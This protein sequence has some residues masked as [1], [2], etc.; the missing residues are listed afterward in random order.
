[1]QPTTSPQSP[2]GYTPLLSATLL[3]IAGIFK[4]VAGA[5]LA[6]LGVI[7]LVVGGSFLSGTS[8]TTGG[9]N[10]STF[11]GALGV[12]VGATLLC[13]SF[14]AFAFGAFDTLAGSLARKGRA[15]GRTL[16]IISC[17]LSLLGFVSSVSASIGSD[18]PGN[19]APLGFASLVG[20]AVN[21]YILVSF[22]KNGAAF[23]R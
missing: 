21:L 17:A 3:W 18:N 16:G 8:G 1:M 14:G 13:V 19:A 15:S 5:L 12:G 6:L 4:L 22:A 10:I 11:T 9:Q 2:H 7:A 23:N 20:A